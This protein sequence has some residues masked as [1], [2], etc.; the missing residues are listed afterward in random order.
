M[1]QPH[2]LSCTSSLWLFLECIL[3]NN[4]GNSEYR[5]FLTCELLSLVDGS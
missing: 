1:P 4:T 5:A 3:Y 2:A